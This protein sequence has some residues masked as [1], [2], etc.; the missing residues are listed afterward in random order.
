M[1]WPRRH[2]RSI[3]ATASQTVQSTSASGLAIP[4]TGGGA[5]ISKRSHRIQRVGDMGTALPPGST[6]PQFG[7]CTRG[8]AGSCLSIAKAPNFREVIVGVGGEEQVPLHTVE[9]SEYR[10][11]ETVCS[12]D[13][14]SVER[15]AGSAE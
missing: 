11:R 10:M 3:G 7:S 1:T 14:V 2:F 5:P 9:P 13:R 15:D 6:K 12:L 4:S 8:N